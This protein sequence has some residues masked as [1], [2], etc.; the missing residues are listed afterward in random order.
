MYLSRLILNPRSR[1]VQSGLRDCQKLHCLILKA[2]P[3]LESGDTKAREEFGVLYRIEISNQRN[4]LSLL[5]QS[6][7][8][9]DWSRLPDGFL[10]TD[11]D[12]LNPSCKS[13]EGVFQELKDGMSLRFRL[14]A[15]PTRRLYADRLEKEINPKKRG[16]RVE[17]RDQQKQ[18][19]WLKR[20]E[21]DCGFY[22]KALRLNAD[23]SNV[24][25]GQEH[26]VIGRIL[27]SENKMTFGSVLF[28]G[29]LVVTDTM[30]FQQALI[31]GIGTGKAYG[32][33]LLSFAPS[34]G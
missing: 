32:F 6:R 5:V 14:R 26:N 12:E 25:A 3:K 27:H 19:E 34:G 17:I 7:V 2:F 10:Q 29:E 24:Q 22:V 23:V 8:Q 18:I 20:K 13:V 11:S 31:N 16:K 28:D 1:D 21:Q 9:P 4:K 30:K 15:N 33:G